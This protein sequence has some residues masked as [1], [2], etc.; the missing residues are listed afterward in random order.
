MV[1]FPTES[2]STGQR[3]E[4]GGGSRD[5]AARHTG[6]GNPVDESRCPY[7]RA[8]RTLLPSALTRER[9]Q[10]QAKGPEN[11]QKTVTNQSDWRMVMDGG[12]PPLEGN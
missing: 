4:K 10:R 2:G 9:D 8:P 7:K 1:A 11:E 6:V 5:R 12:T 3:V